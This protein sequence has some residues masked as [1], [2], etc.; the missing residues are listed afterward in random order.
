MVNGLLIK[1]IQFYKKKKHVFPF[2]KLVPLVIVDDAKF[3]QCVKYTNSCSISSSPLRDFNGMTS[4]L[5]ST[6]HA[7]QKIW[8]FWWWAAHRM[9]RSKTYV[10][11][12]YFSVF[13]YFFLRKHEKKTKKKAQCTSCGVIAFS[14]SQSFTQTNEEKAM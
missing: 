11:Y 4:T 14:E 3:S 10:A 13:S 9:P 2:Y 12:M 1:W 5:F 6:V 8:F 7:Q